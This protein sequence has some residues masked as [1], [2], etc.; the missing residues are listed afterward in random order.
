MKQDICVAQRIV[1]Q[2]AQATER[3]LPSI[4]ASIQQ[5]VR[6]GVTLKA[7]SRPRRARPQG[8]P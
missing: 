8:T 6:D 2:F 4:A 7:P 1:R 3:N 5:A